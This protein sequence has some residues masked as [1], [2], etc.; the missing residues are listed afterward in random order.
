MIY[1]AGA[2]GQ[3]IESS[4]SRI[5]LLQI[6]GTRGPKALFVDHHRALGGKSGGTEV[7]AEDVLHVKTLL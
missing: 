3:T 4:V 1:W 5:R 6:S 7:R 2:C